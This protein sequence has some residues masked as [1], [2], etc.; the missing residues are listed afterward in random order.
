MNDANSRYPVEEH[1][2]FAAETRCGAVVVT[3]ILERWIDFRTVLDL[4]CGT[5]IWLRVLRD[6]G[7]R[8]VFGVDFEA[9]DPADLVVDPDLVLAADL[10][11]KLDLHLR[12]DLVVCL[13]VAEHVDAQFADV[14]VDNCVRHADLI[15][16]SAAL[17]GQQGV[18]H[19][20]EQLPQYW[21]ERFQRR[22][23]IVLDLDS[24]A[25]LGRS[26]D[27]GLVPTEHAFVRQGW[28]DP[29]G[30]IAGQDRL[31]FRRSTGRSAPGIYQMVFDTGTNRRG[32][33]RAPLCGAH[34]GRSGA[35]ADTTGPRGCETCP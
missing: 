24:A 7:R 17:P 8:Q 4:G 25:D 19:I 32:G 1:Q 31:G 3:N 35:H 14:V 28:L 23:Y 6:G 26:T 13:E 34:A 11:K 15:L 18:D 12:Y 10:G 27:T 16:F 22:G 5:G 2:R 20:N 21:V 29:P 9:N 33:S 30:D